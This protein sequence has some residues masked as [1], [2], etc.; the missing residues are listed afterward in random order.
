MVLRR[1]DTMLCNLGS[2]RFQSGRKRYSSPSINIRLTCVEQFG[3]LLDKLLQLNSDDS[4]DNQKTSSQASAIA[5]LPVGQGATGC[6]ACIPW[7]AGHS[8]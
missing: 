5:G 6:V 4:N 3:Q 1:Q 8:V 2:M 7:Y